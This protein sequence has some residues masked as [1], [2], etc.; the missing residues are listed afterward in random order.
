MYCYANN[1]TIY[2]TVAYE[3]TTATAAAAAAATILLGQ[4][5]RTTAVLSSS[6]GKPFFR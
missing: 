4:M 5:G 3:T 2:S 6:V 1:S